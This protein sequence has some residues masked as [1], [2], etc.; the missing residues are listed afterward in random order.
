MV[1]LPSAIAVGKMSS[2]PVLGMSEL[3]VVVETTTLLELDELFELDEL[4]ELLEL[5]GLDE[6]FEL[7]EDELDFSSLDL[8]LSELSLFSLVFSDVSPPSLSVIENEEFSLPPIFLAD[9]LVATTMIAAIK[10]NIITVVR[11]AKNTTFLRS[12]FSTASGL[13]IIK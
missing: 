12:F 3:E 8:F 1:R 7:D 4:E 6:L 13:Y 2:G 9:F 10:T 5:E 11:T